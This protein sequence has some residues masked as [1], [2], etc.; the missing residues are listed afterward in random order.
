MANTTFTGNVRENGDGSRT[1]IAGSMAATAN[2]HIPNTL[3][4]GNGN[5]QKSETDLTTVILPKG[6]VVYKIVIW[7]GSAAGGGTMDIGYTPIAGGVVVANPDGFADGIAV[8]AK[9]ETAA[10]GAGGTAGADLGGISTIINTVEY[11]PAIVNG[12]GS[13][14]QLRVT[15]TASASFAGT[16]SGTL[17]YFVADEKNGAE[18]A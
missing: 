14:E 16:A 1:S 5:V 15:H 13:R 2:F 6:A 8:D 17:Y 4:A 12:T 9:S 11:G 10:V 3:T 18:S 7:D